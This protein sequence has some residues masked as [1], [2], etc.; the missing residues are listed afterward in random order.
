MVKLTIS[1]F[2]ICVEPLPSTP[3]S[4]SSNLRELKKRGE[5]G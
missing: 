3:H 2:L 5:E 1:M 4:N